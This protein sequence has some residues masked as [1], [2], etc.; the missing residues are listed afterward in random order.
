MA[1]K[2]PQ[3]IGRRLGKAVVGT[4]L[5]LTLLAA[6]AKRTTPRVERELRHDEVTSVFKNKAIQR[7][8]MD[9]NSNAE[10]LYAKLNAGKLTK[11]D[12]QRLSAN[13]ISD[14]NE[15]APEFKTAGMDFRTIKSELSTLSEFLVERPIKNGINDPYF[16]F[17]AELIALASFIQLAKNVRSLGFKRGFGKTEKFSLDNYRHGPSPAA[18]TA[19]AFLIANTSHISLIVGLISNPT[20]RYYVMKVVDAARRSSR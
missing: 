4:A 7:S 5:G 11:L 13:L 16:M 18:I 2:K 10:N 15:F 14:L 3:P 8:S 20:L 6:D 9:V 1:V 19:V 12:I 17:A